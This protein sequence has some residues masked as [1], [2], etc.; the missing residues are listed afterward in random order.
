MDTFV[1]QWKL[2][3]ETVRR[4]L[5]IGSEG[6]LHLMHLAQELLLSV[7]AGTDARLCLDLGVD[8]LQAAWSKDP[9]DGQ[10]AGQLVALHEKWP[11]LSEPVLAMVRH[12]AGQWRTP[13]D[14][15]YYRRLAQSRDGEKIRHFLSTQV[16]REPGNLYWRQQTLALGFFEHDHL[17][18]QSVLNEPWPDVMRPALA[19]LRGDW[20][21]LD[22][23][24]DDAGR[25]Y[26]SGVGVD[27]SWRR[28]EHLYSTGQLTQARR[29]W[30][31]L[32]ETRPWLVG[33]TLRLHDVIH[34]ER[35]QR[36][37][38]NG[39]VAVCLYSFNKGR[40]LDATLS[41]LFDAASSDFTVW[42]VDNGSSDSTADV[43]AAWRDRVG[44]R[45]HVISLHVNI[46]APAARNWLMHVPQ[47]RE[48]SWM[49]YLDDDVE[50]PADWL[51]R[52]ARAVA[53]YPD[54]GV[55][56]CKVVDHV[57]ST[58]LQ[59]VDLHL[60]PVLSE[61]DRQADKR[62]KVSDLHHQTLD[63][64]QFDYLRPCA[65]VTGCCHLFRM[66]SLLECGGFDLR[67]SPSQYDDLEHDIRRNLSGRYAVYQGFLS[68]R[69]K[70]RTGKSSQVSPAEFGNSF[71]NM[72][73]L[74][75]KY[76]QA[77]F[78]QIMA[79]EADVLAR[80]F[81]RKRSAVLRWLEDA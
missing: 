19:M 7:S 52:L 43:L 34:G 24:R 80:D 40:E 22:G 62:F 69:H 36:S 72:H 23:R 70:K 78:E 29:L 48:C 59:S 25:E 41:S 5:L 4:G 9:L 39:P 66:D 3:P 68:V 27:A 44:D 8:L 50:L 46:G 56:G 54:A 26:E 28:A 14:L 81:W 49:V 77:Q 37:L 12:V 11:R 53:V 1:T 2:L 31:E 58:V 55:W 45:L 6:K 21:W 20:A 73:K 32:L 67:F 38:L 18:I 30:R 60:E 10:L 16:A 33:E 35:E 17:L 79:W 76:G 47:V 15:R 74:Q 71:A 13:D 65:S 64:G 51:G 75:K 61:E 57:T 42:V 63:F